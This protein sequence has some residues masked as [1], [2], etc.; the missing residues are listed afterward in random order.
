MA[1]VRKRGKS[2][3]AVVRK[4]GHSQI[5]KTFSSLSAAKKWGKQAEVEL[6]KGVYQD[7]K[8]AQRMTVKE[9]VDSYNS[10][11]LRLKK[12]YRKEQSRVAVVKRMLGVKILANVT[13][14]DLVS[15]RDKRLNEVSAA[16]V[17]LELS[18]IDRSLKYAQFEL[19]VIFPNGIPR[20][21]RPRKPKGRNRRVTPQE[22]H[23]LLSS[24]DP[25]MQVIVQL[26]VET[27]M[28]RGEI[29]KVKRKDIN[30]QT[31]TI[32][33]YDT[34]NGDDRVVPLSS[35]AIGAL[36]KLPARLDGGVFDMH[37]DTVSKRFL[38]A[39]RANDIQDLR[40]HDLRHEA[41]SR[42][43]EKGLNPMEVAAI[44]GHKTLQMLKRYTHL[45]AEDLAKK[46][47]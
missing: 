2:Y 19:G 30:Y 32:H 3:Q 46:L 39:C 13:S 38:E 37:P 31:R 42:L 17:C 5:T 36:K 9:A 11:Y 15:Y 35:V 12:S 6:E 21:R 44:S 43:F 27:G 10:E 20:V 25:V 16:S 28:R 4:K 47:G 22:L 14:T 33:L 8:L 24:S 23:Q 1:T 41:V 26:A 29:V 18:L 34:K 45:R 7:L 40:F